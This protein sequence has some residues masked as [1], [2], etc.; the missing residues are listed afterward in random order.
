[1]IHCGTPSNQVYCEPVIGFTIIMDG[2]II[3]HKIIMKRKA[4]KTPIKTV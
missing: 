2:A 3:I 4:M 1:M